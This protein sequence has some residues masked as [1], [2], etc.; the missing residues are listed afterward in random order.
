MSACVIV[1]SKTPELV[2]KMLRSFA[3]AGM[4]GLAEAKLGWNGTDAGLE[5]VLDLARRLG[6]RLE[7]RKFARYGFACECDELARESAA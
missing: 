7:A 6:I 5:E 2:S 3:A 4:A 1:L